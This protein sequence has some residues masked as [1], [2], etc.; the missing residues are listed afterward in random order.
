MALV[1]ANPQHSIDAIS[2]KQTPK[3]LASVACEIERRVESN[4]TD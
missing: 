4:R 2:P 1:H 3:W